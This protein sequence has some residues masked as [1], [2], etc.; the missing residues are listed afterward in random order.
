VIQHGRLLCGEDVRAGLPQPSRTDLLVAGAEFAL[1]TLAVADDALEGIRR[2]EALLAQGAR[3][4]TKLVLFPVRFLYSAETG[5]VG[6]NHAAVEHYVAGGSAPASELV[7]A[8]LAW[9][10]APPDRAAA[11][12]LLEQEMIPLYLHYID[13]HVARLADAGR[14]DLCEAFAQWRARIAA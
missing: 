4:V 6:T 5:L 12:A 13:D 8:A 7:A 3:R 1:G 10:T 11:A 14:P 9:R 2:P